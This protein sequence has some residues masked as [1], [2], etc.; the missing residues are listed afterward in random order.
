MFILGSMVSHRTHVMRQAGG[1]PS[2]VLI[3]RKSSVEAGGM[4]SLKQGDFESIS[5]CMKAGQLG[6]V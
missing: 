2:E 6:D 3:Q 5:S 1:M 4:N